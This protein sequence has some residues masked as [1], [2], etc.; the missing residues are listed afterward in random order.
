MISFIGGTIYSEPDYSDGLPGPVNFN[1]CS[2]ADGE[3]GKG[4]FGSIP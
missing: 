1:A 2:D 3:D 4:P